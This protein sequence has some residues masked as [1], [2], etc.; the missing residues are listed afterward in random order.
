M[1]LPLG[2]LTSPRAPLTLLAFVLLLLFDVSL[3][4]PHPGCF[5]CFDSFI[6]GS[7]DKDD[8]PQLYM[9]DPSGISYVGDPAV[10][11]N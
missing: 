8:G 9:V 4:P 1:S 2:C 3:L 10:S 7:F 11:Y 5:F 6:L